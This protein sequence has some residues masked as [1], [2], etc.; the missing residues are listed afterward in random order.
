MTSRKEQYKKASKTN[1]TNRKN[2]G[3]KRFNRWIRPE[4]LNHLDELLTKLRKEE[5]DK[6]TRL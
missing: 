6:N 3:W 2:E 4:W 5:N 1:Y